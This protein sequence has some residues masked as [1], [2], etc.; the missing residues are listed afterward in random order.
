M[1]MLKEKTLFAKPE[2][3]N[4]MLKSPARVSRGHETCSSISWLRNP[5]PAPDK[6]T[7]RAQAY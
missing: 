7:L 6:H 4:K 2:A 1:A 3:M 5:C